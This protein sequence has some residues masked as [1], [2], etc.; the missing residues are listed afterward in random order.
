MFVSEIVGLPKL[1]GNAMRAIENTMQ[2]YFID[3]Y[4]KAVDKAVD[5]A[6]AGTTYDERV[7]SRA[8]MRDALRRTAPGLI[9]P[10]PRWDEFKQTLAYFELMIKLEGK[11]KDHKL[12]RILKKEF[13]KERDNWQDVPE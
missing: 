7:I 3:S 12:V 6:M 4:H 9:W 13:S 11:A 2:D 5:K 10:R 1:H 8:A